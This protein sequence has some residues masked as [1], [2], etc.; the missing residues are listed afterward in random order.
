MNLSGNPINICAGIVLFNPEIN[1]L[2]DNI[3][4]IIKQVPLLV[5]I[6]NKS[7]NIDQVK[8]LIKNIKNIILIE[9]CENKGIAQA[10]NVILEVSY[11]QGYDWVLTLDQDSV[12]DKHLVEK[13][14]EFII[15]HNEISNAACLTCDIIDRN[16]SSN[17]SHKYF[18]YVDYCITSGSLMNITYTL[19]VGGF[20]ESLFIDKVDTD[21]CMNLTSKGYKIVKIGYKGLL[22]EIGHA[23]QIN[24]L[25]RKW[26]LYNHAPFRRYYM[27]RNAS[28]L[29]KKYHNKKSLKIFLKE[30][31]Q[32]ILV[33]IFENKRIEK[34]LK[35]ITGFIDGFRIR[36]DY[37]R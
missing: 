19:E 24:I 8:D 15:K 32:F 14:K 26:E 31:F 21:I 28:Y 27:C 7:D 9:N 17:I 29:L 18:D 5:L 25:F 37:F 23:R 6:D 3:Y 2:K 35:G 1:R 33:F 11:K 36:E 30:I 10:L 20:D 13:Y 16:F 4:S 34:F 22:H 12:A